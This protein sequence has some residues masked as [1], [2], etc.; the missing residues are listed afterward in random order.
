MKCSEKA[1]EEGGGR[2]GRGGVDKEHVCSNVLVVVCEATQRPRYVC[3]V[4]QRRRDDVLRL[5]ACV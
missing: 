4:L 5:R 3:S 2:V 1:E